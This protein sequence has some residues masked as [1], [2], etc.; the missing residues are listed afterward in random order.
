[1]VGKTQ[2]CKRSISGLKNKIKNNTAGQNKVEGV[3][4]E[5]RRGVSHRPRNTLNKNN[6][7]PFVNC[8]GCGGCGHIHGPGLEFCPTFRIGRM[9]IFEHAFKVRLMFVVPLG[10]VEGGI[11]DNGC[12]F[13][14][15]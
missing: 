12:A 6:S 8:E 2:R 11:G 14:E 15:H 5:C 3:V 13:V 7:A 10:C 9:E 1:M 4:F